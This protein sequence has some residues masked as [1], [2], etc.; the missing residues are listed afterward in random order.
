MTTI[1]AVSAP[2]G[3]AGAAGTVALILILLSVT[4]GFVLIVRALMIKLHNRVAASVDRGVHAPGEHGGRRGAGTRSEG[5]LPTAR[6]GRELKARY[7]R[8][9]I[10]KTEFDEQLRDLQISEYLEEGE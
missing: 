5:E 4:V 8:G 6:S 9:E 10:S 2:G 3:A 1:L 7:L